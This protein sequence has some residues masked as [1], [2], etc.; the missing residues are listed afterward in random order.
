M[1]VIATY[2]NESQRKEI[3]VL[4]AIIMKLIQYFPL[5][6]I[7]N[8]QEKVLEEIEEATKK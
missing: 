4:F 8:D 7:R 3:I 6:K 1:Y 5:Y 2:Y